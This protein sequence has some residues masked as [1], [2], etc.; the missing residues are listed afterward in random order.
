MEKCRLNSW[1]YWVMKMSEKERL[2][3]LG[4]EVPMKTYLRSKAA[5]ALLKKPFQ[6]FIAETL[7]KELDRLGI[8]DP[9]DLADLKVS[10]SSK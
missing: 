5:A 10:K 4:S 1:T 7:N 3:K 9:D 8:P 6:Q 2:Q